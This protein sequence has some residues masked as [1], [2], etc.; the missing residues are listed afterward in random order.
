MNE[1]GVSCP[2]DKTKQ[3]ACCTARIDE[4][5]FKMKKFAFIYMHF[6]LYHI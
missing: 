5:M 1:Y 2:T 3:Y 6:F 4:G